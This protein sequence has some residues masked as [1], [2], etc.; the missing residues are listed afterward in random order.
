MGRAL[1]AN[2]GEGSAHSKRTGP[3]RNADLISLPKGSTRWHKR[4]SNPG[5]L[6]P[7]SYALPTAP[8]WLAYIFDWYIINV[9]VRC[10]R[11]NGR[12]PGPTLWGYLGRITWKCRGHLPCSWSRVT[13]N[14]KKQKNDQFCGS[15]SS[16]FETSQYHP[17]KFENSRPSHE[18]EDKAN[19][20]VNIRMDGRT[21]RSIL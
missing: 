21:F 6:D 20:N 7:D 5:P 17:V 12:T 4:V 9:F 2:S 14:R 10:W 13:G 8:H 19:R 18:S 11:T 3:P 16:D 1:W 15:M